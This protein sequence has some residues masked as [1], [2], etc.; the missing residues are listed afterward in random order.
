MMRQ[1][2]PQR[3]ERALIVFDNMAW[4]DMDDSIYDVEAEKQEMRWRPFL[5]EPEPAFKLNPSDPEPVPL[6]VLRDT[7]ELCARF[8]VPPRQ[9]RRRTPR[10]VAGSYHVRSD[11]VAVNQRRAE[12][13]GLGGEDG[14][15]GFLVHELLHATGHPKRLG[16]RTTGDYSPDGYDLEEGTVLAAQ[17]IV[18][19]ELGFPDEA[20]DWHTRG[21]ESLPS[22]H[23]AAT[24]AAHWF[25]SP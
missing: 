21:Y 13:N 19:A 1:F 3:Q 6:Q 12:D 25:L 2:D 20:L 11:I 10:H 17:R 14:Y 9:F 4:A 16:R 8:R 24:L 7:R 18:L 22:D 5:P 15:Y 23:E